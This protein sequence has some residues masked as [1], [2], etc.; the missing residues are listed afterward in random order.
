MDKL[1]IEYIVDKAGWA[2]A[3]IS[4]G[5]GEVNITV[6]Y[7]NNSLLELAQMALCL[8]N[9]G[10]EARVIFMDEP[11][12]HQFQVITNGEEANYEVLW[13]SDWESW[14]LRKKKEFHSVLKGVTTVQRIVHQITQVLWRIHEN[15]G[16]EKYKE[17]WVEHEFPVQEF[18][19]LSNA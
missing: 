5:E 19:V 7:L 6:S 11:G 13:Y 8:K 1:S 17:L 2:Q 3:I 16:P 15:I 18:K 12:E 14:G 10:K 9:G 4:N